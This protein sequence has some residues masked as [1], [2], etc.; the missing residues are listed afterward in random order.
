M[1]ASFAYCATKVTVAVVPPA[2]LLTLTFVGAAAGMSNVALATDAPVIVNVYTCDGASKTP[3]NDDVVLSYTSAVT[4]FVR[5]YG[6]PA[7]SS[8]STTTFARV[9]SR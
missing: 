3:L 6:P 8:K 1:C 2:E 4:L 9:E 5:T 7:E